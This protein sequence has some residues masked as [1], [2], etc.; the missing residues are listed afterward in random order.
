MEMYLNAIFSQKLTGD[1]RKALVTELRR[2]NPAVERELQ[3]FKDL[4]GALKIRIVSVY[5]RKPARRLIQKHQESIT[6]K[7][8]KD[9]V[10]AAGTVISWAREGETYNP[11]EKEDAVLGF[12]LSLELQIPSNG[13]H[14]DM[15]KFDHKDNTYQLILEELR[16]C[17]RWTPER[18]FAMESDITDFSMSKLSQ[19]RLSL[20]LVVDKMNEQNV[21]RE[22][23]GV[24]MM[25]QQALLNTQVLLQ[26]AE[27]VLC[28]AITTK[29]ES[30]LDY[31]AAALER[32]GPALGSALQ[33]LESHFGHGNY[34]RGPLTA[35]RMQA[36]LPS[37]LGFNTRIQN[38]LFDGSPGLSPARPELDRDRESINKLGSLRCAGRAL[39]SVTPNPESIPFEHLYFPRTLE[40][41]RDH[42][43]KSW[44]EKAIS[45]FTKLT[46]EETQLR[47]KRYAALRSGNAFEKVLVEF[48]P[49]PLHIDSSELSR[50]REQFVTTVRTI[51]QINYGK[52]STVPVRGVSF[53]KSPDSACFVVVLK[54]D[55]L[56]GLDE[57]FHNSNCPSVKGRVWLALRYAQS[58]A[59]L[60]S[61]CL[62]HGLINPLNLYLQQAPSAQSLP[63]ARFEVEV[64]SPMLAGF[65]ISRPIGGVSDLIDVEDPLF[66]VHL[67]PERREHGYDKE[68]QEPRHDVFSL[69]MVLIETGIWALFSQFSKYR[70][71]E[72]DDVRQQFCQNLR[73]KFDGSDT[74]GNMPSE[75]RDII[76]Y[77][78]GRSYSLPGQPVDSKQSRLL[79]QLD[80]PRASRVVE[81]L[82]RL[83]EN[84]P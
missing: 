56:I 59:T 25:L 12:P 43:E 62:C 34:S 80:E 70:A 17:S 10:G 84:L 77:C 21:P 68:R 15:T 82:A 81:A 6:S 48:C 35:E 26:L 51:M 23:E 1:A 75:Y 4:V 58:I 79:R 41:E 9:S 30:Q 31:V 37:S 67:H 18:T 46:F 72:S 63:A 39:R 60:H 3:D 76:S 73:K 57:A 65:D 69:G 38:V 40:L 24:G 36:V 54:A 71:A 33:E 49:C 14:S 16:K 28:R 53:I 50:R 13:D 52:L 2:D 8:S 29:N 74:D 22:L 64:T 61:A 5:E 11:L 27:D 47:P 32:E 7:D 55:N 44:L 83:Y 19:L 42:Q 20:K 78:L 66:R 45:F